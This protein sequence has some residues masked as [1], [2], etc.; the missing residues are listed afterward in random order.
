[1][2]FLHQ[3]KSLKGACVTLASDDYRIRERM[4]Y[5]VFQWPH[6]KTSTLRHSVKLKMNV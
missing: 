3:S 5:F 2:E 1:M 6:I 4:C